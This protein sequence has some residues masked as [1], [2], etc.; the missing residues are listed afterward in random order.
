MPHHPAAFCQVH[1]LFPATAIAIA[2]GVSNFGLV[3][4][5][6]NCPVCNRASEIIPGIYD[7][8]YG[9]LNVIVD[10]S[11]SP[12]ALTALKNIVERLQRDEI[13]SRQAVEEAAQIDPRFGRALLIAAK[14]G[15]WA[16]TAVLMLVQLY[17]QLQD[18]SANAAQ[19]EALLQALAE[20]T[21]VLEQIAAQA[22]E[23]EAEAD[24][25]KKGA[26]PAG[27]KAEPEPTAKNEKSKRRQMVNK[28]RREALK[29]RR[30]QFGSSHQRRPH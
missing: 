30:S 26:A 14:I 9:R 10:P 15:A 12:E 20:Q 6:T 7:A 13:T 27:P 21:A 4:V 24:S 16:V 25:N 8:A 28:A 3:G 11:I 18:G 29:L 5:S 2:D 23:D 17:L 19:Q 1:G 22:S